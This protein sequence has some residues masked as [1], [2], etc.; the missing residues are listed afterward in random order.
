MEPIITKVNIKKNP[1]KASFC[2]DERLWKQVL[3]VNKKV[4]IC[5]VT[6]GQLGNPRDSDASLGVWLEGLSAVSSLRTLAYEKIT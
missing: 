5:T 2:L 1:S 6:L 4:P 3:N